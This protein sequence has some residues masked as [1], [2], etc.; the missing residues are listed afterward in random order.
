MNFIDTSNVT[1]MFAV[2]AGTEFNGDI[3]KWDISNV[4]SMKKMFMYKPQIEAAIKIDDVDSIYE[5][6]IAAL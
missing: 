2:F 4:T 5:Q 3:S 1:D 6:A